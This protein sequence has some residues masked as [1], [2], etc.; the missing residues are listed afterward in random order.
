M[1][2]LDQ[3][4]ESRKQPAGGFHQ[5]V[6]SRKQPAGGFHQLVESRK[7]PAASLNPHSSPPNKQLFLKAQ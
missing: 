7:Q 4:V 2:T 5:L 1:Q 3:L 6:E